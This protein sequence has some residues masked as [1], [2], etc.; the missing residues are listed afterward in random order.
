MCSY[1]FPFDLRVRGGYGDI[2]E[3]VATGGGLGP[4]IVCSCSAGRQG[5][6]CRHRIA[7]L[8]GRHDRLHSGHEQWPALKAMLRESD[9]AVVLADYVAAEAAHE[10][11]ASRRRNAARELGRLMH[12]DPANPCGV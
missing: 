7:L 9:L 11:A 12:D 2:Y 4:T 1:V 6:Y 5:R 3:V 8:T 10:A